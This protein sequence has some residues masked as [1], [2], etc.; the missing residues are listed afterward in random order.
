LAEVVK[1]GYVDHTQ[2]DPES[3]YYDPKSQQDNPRWM[4]VDIHFKQKFSK[5]L[6]L[7]KIKEMPEITEIGLVKKGHRLSIMPVEQNEFE[8]LLGKC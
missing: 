8:W 2:F 1:E 4:M 3:K 7:S 6:S 5:I